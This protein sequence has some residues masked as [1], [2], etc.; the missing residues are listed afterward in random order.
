MKRTMWASLGLVAIL[1]LALMAGCGEKAEDPAS[2]L[3]AGKTLVVAQVTGYTPSAAATSTKVGDITKNR[4]QRITITVD[5]SDDRL[6]GEAEMTVNNDVRDD[7]SS[8]GWGTFKFTN[9][10]GTWEGDWSGA[11][12]AKVDGNIYI[13]TRLTGAGDYEGLI[14]YLLWVQPAESLGFTGGVSAASGYIE[15]AK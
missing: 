6:A 7:G 13:L 3:A 14:A 15:Q 9:D 5:A 8:T 11:G 12:E 2:G 1:V 4:D 10:G